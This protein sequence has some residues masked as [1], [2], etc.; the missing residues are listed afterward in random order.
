MLPDHVLSSQTIR[1]TFKYPRNIPREDLVDYSLGGVGLNDASEGL[2]TNAWRGSLSDGEITLETTGV[3]P[4]V[5]FTNPSVIRFS[6]T[7]DQN[8]NPFIAF[9]TENTSHY[10]WF[11]SLTSD[12][13]LSTLPVGSKYATAALDETRNRL[14]GTSDVILA[15]LRDGSL[16]FREQRDRYLNEYLLES[17]L[18]NYKIYQIGMNNVLRFQFQLRPL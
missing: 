17:G 11:D 7:F 1:S 5:V 15:Y 6:F 2:E 3:E 13:V 12:Y 10:Y 8:M 18:D 4:V 16:Y 9:D 14:T